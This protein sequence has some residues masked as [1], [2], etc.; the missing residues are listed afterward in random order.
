M[1]APQADKLVP[2]FGDLFDAEP[3]PANGFLDIPNLPG[4][5]VNVSEKIELVRPYTHGKWD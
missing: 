5:G 2:I 3:L 1:M 4:W